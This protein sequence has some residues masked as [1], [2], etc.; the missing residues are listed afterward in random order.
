MSEIDE[1]L[2]AL[3]W[4]EANGSMD[5]FGISAATSTDGNKL[6]AFMDIIYEAMAEAMAVLYKDG[7]YQ[8]PTLFNLRLLSLG[9][10]GL[11]MIFAIVRLLK[12]VK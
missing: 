1:Y 9:R 8:K 3:E 7:K 6:P 11:T 5:S 10:I 12:P 4:I 2:D